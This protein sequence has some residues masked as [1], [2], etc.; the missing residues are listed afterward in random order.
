[1]GVMKVAKIRTWMHCE[2]QAN[3]FC[4]WTNVG[5]T[6]REESVTTHFGT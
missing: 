6:A 1:M 3:M 5:V 2:G 4:G